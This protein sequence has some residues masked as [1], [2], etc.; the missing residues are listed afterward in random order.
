M[1]KEKPILHH[2]DDVDPLAQTQPT[3]GLTRALPAK[4][5]RSRLP[6]RNG[7]PL[8]KAGCSSLLIGI[9]V[10]LVILTVYLFFPDRTNILILGIDDRQQGQAVGRSDTMI[11]VSLEPLLGKVS[12]LSIP[13]D[14]WVSVPGYGEGRINTA[15]FYAEAEQP[16]SGMLAARQVIEQNF[17]VNVDYTVRLR[18][19]NFVELV[20]TIG[21]LEIVLDEQM[22]GYSTGSHNLTAEEAL[23]FVRDREGSDD[24][25]RM[26][27]GQIFVNAVLRKMLALETIGKLP[28]ILVGLNQTVESDIPVYL[29]P[30]LSLNL[31]RAGPN[32]INS[33]TISRELVTPFTT[34]GGAQVLAPN[35]ELINPIIS[36]MFGND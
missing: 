33:Q 30:R 18:F 31:L 4:P 2:Y 12:M 28:E 19:D 3:S 21:G 9:A 16:G 35:W 13:R 14:L 29:W 10:F 34:D 26:Q 1:G 7:S 27:R 15:H 11:L 20:N 6:R 22:S 32:G 36:E 24:F 17:S 23:A 25:F 5:H 8:L